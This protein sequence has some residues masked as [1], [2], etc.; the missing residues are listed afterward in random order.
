[1]PVLRSSTT[2]FAHRSRI[3]R[4]YRVFLHY[5][6][7]PIS[8]ATHFSCALLHWHNA[9]QSEDHSSSSWSRVSLAVSRLELQRWTINQSIIM[10][11]SPVMAPSISTDKISSSILRRR[12]LVRKTSSRLVQQ[13]AIPLQRT[14]MWRLKLLWIA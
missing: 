5:S 7:L 2:S 3:C 4:S 8:G 10:L 14:Q 6:F 1:M 9:I 11:V 12:H 13:R